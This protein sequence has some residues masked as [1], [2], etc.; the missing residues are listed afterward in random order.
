MEE[1]CG[2]E[3]S[4]PDAETPIRANEEDLTVT[5]EPVDP[6]ESEAERLERWTNFHA[7]GARVKEAEATE[8]DDLLF[9]SLLKDTQTDPSSPNYR[10]EAVRTAFWDGVR[11]YLRSSDSDE[12]EGKQ[13]SLN[14]LSVEERG[15]G[16]REAQKKK[17]ETIVLS[18]EALKNAQRSATMESIGNTQYLE[19][20]REKI[21]G[22]THNRLFLDLNGDYEVVRCIYGVVAKNGMARE[23]END[24]ENEM[25]KMEKEN[26]M[27][28][29]ERVGKMK[30]RTWKWIRSRRSQDT[31]LRWNYDQN[32]HHPNQITCQARPLPTSTDASSAGVSPFCSDIDITSPSPVARQISHFNQL[33]NSTPSSSNVPPAPHVPWIPSQPRASSSNSST[34]STHD[35]TSKPS[36]AIPVR[37]FMRMRSQHGAAA[38][39]H[40]SPADRLRKASQTPEEQ[41]K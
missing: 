16:K 13:S 6:A 32:R 36:V 9:K 10:S 41:T 23:P 29:R 40:S 7:P 34:S 35:S 18:Y 17:R 19:A 22:M 24:G 38:Y 39:I 3:Y 5:I 12:E 27:K 33:L 20:M 1:E 8:E 25:K 30:E 37:S 26:E 4:Q 2:T 14:I 28:M 21:Q 15:Q 11:S 31:P